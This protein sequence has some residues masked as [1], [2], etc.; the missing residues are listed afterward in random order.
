MFLVEAKSVALLIPFRADKYSGPTLFIGLYVA[1]CMKL[2]YCF[3]I[4]LL[5]FF[6]MSKYNKDASTGRAI[7]LNLN[8]ENKVSQRRDCYKQ[9]TC[10]KTLIS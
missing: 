3:V 10:L 5:H 6:I 7:D 9:Y 8:K 1:P 4:V 2:F